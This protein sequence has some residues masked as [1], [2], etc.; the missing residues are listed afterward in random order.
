MRL[1]IDLSRLPPCGGGGF[2]RFAH[3][4][5]PTYWVV[6]GWV[7]LSVLFVFIAWVVLFVF[8]AFYVFSIWV[9]GSPTHPTK[10]ATFQPT[11]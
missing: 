2:N 1:C 3:S 9:V 7:V 10:R 8:F 4:A 6:G 11:Q 5:E